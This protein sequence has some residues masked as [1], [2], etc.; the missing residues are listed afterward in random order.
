MSE[1]LWFCW[2]LSRESRRADKAMKKPVI[3]GLNPEIWQV[4]IP[5]YQNYS[6]APSWFLGSVSGDEK[7]RRFWS[8]TSTSVSH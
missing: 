8:I 6:L 5:W 7:V 2:R 1:I 4:W 3:S